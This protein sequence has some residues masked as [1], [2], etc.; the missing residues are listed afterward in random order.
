[1]SL[2]CN[3]NWVINAI[4]DDM[5]GIARFHITTDFTVDDSGRSL[6]I[7]GVKHI[8]ARHNINRDGSCCVIVNANMMIGR[9]NSMVFRG[10]GHVDT[11]VDI[12]VGL[13]ISC[14][15]WDVVT[16][17]HMPLSID[18]LIF[19]KTMI[20]LTIYRQSQW[21]ARVHFPRNLTANQRVTLLEFC[22]VQHVILRHT[23][24]TY[25]G[26]NAGIDNNVLIGMH[27][28][29]VIGVIRCGHRGGDLRISHQIVSADIDFVP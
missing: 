27:C 4:N 5:Y 2:I 13:D 20:N 3:G 28:D 18:P 16:H 23:I 7:V 9:G 14:A 8:I 6:L 19:H 10:I 24:H 15:H 29:H 1:M 26:I 11:G 12:R 21:V 17:D 25:R 22:P